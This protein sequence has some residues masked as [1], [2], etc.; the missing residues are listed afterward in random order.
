[1]REKFSNMYERERESGERESGV[2]E[3][4]RER[5]GERERYDGG[6]VS[7]V[8]TTSS[9]SNRAGGSTSVT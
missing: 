9:G 3:R 1:M 4:G 2:R 6:K 8:S 7:M 5:E